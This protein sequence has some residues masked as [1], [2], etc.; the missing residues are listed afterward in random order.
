MLQTA[1]WLKWPK[2]KYPK[3]CG[4][5]VSILAFKNLQWL[6]A[7][8]DSTA[9]TQLVTELTLIK[10]L[11]G[12]KRQ[13][14]NFL[15]IYILVILVSKQFAT[16]LHNYVVHLFVSVI[17]PLMKVLLGLKRQARN[18]LDIYI[19]VILV[20]KQFATFLQR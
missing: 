11:L 2:C 6:L 19:L 17:Q 12:S 5:D 18:F 9:I 13:A 3:K 20:S 16:F 10:V 14:L 15:D 7:R 1:Y 4:P 8:S